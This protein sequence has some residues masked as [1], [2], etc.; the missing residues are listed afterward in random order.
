MNKYFG[1]TVFS[2][3]ASMD[4]DR[5]IQGWR[6]LTHLVSKLTVRMGEKSYQE[7]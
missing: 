2:Q 4:I 1:A 7:Q 3:V 6:Y 5:L